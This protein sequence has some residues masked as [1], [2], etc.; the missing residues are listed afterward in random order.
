M[1]WLE[2]AFDTTGQVQVVN[3]FTIPIG[4][5]ANIGYERPPEGVETPDGQWHLIDIGDY[6]PENYCSYVKEWVEKGVQ[7]VGGCCSTTPE[8]IKEISKFMKG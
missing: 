8:H 2:S 1:G 7:I 4:A 6:T 5:Y 3:H